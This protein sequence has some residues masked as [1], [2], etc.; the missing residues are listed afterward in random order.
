M[1]TPPA[2]ALE[3]APA[4]A[5][6]SRTGKSA[7]IPK[8]IAARVVAVLSTILALVLIVHT[9]RVFDQTCDEPS[10]LAAGVEWWVSHTYKLDPID[11]PLAQIFIAA[12]P[13][14]FLHAHS[15][16]AEHPCDDHDVTPDGNTPDEGNAILRDGN[17]D[18]ILTAARLGILPFFL[19][20]VALVWLRT[21][22]WLGEAGAALAV[23]LLCTCE[24]VL[25]HAG[26]A[27]TD[28]CFMATFFL[29]LDR[30]WQ[31]AIA[32]T[33]RNAIFAG[34]A[35]GL[36]L[37]SKMTG[38]PYLLLSPM[39][40]FAGLW[41]F[42]RRV[43]L[44]QQRPGSR[45]RWTPRLIGL[46]AAALLA[47]LLMLWATY[48]FEVTAAIP[49][50]KAAHILEKAHVPE[51][52]AE[53]LFDHV[54]AGQYL[55]GLQLSYWMNAK[56]HPSYVLG[57]TNHHGKPYFF[58]VA[59][60]V[61]TPIP[62][63]LFALGGVLLAATRLRKRADP[64]PILLFIG[65]ATPLSFGI[66]AHVN[67][68][69]RHVLAIYPFLAMLAAMA[70]VWCWRL[71]IPYRVAVAALL[72]W[73]LAACIHAS[74]DFLPYFNE[75][76]AAHADFFLVDS[77]VDWGQDM[78]RVPPVLRQLHADRI[79]ITRLGAADLNRVGLPPWQILP[80]NTPVTGWVVM[81]DARLKLDAPAYDWIKPYKPVAM[82]GRSFFIYYIPPP[83]P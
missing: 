24:P 21:R 28:V 34:L 46:P 4:T 74:P 22:G 71:A 14:L 50:P 23:F 42:R 6:K 13:T 5:A 18:R 69:L 76:A 36:A 70:I 1:T 19:L 79:S 66:A 44:L 75:A 9:Y 48:R 33:L 73:Q 52:I 68:G 43:P 63:L 31:F 20:T 37:V 56:P 54:P 82:A 58:P 32:P 45:L 64:Y 53:H 40:L 72:L 78:K 60:L 10:H 41:L 77:D 47:C 65:I 62:F 39:L 38:L 81:S 80:P 17:Y 7:P 15:H 12:G 2:P 59:I 16:C 3:P 29:A 67:L 49:S 57:Q 8:S 51:R 35:A 25:A 27:A 55:I 11:P 83:Q 30:L 61:K 26:V